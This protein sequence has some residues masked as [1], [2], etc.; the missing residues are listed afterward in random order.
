MKSY[1]FIV[2]AFV[3]VFIFALIMGL[4]GHYFPIAPWLDPWHWWYVPVV[5]AHLA[6]ICICILSFSACCYASEHADK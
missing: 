5:V 4:I 1:L 6:I 3:Q 2:L